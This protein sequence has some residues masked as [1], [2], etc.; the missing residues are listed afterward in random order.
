[1]RYECQ[2]RAGLFLDKTQDR[3]YQQQTDLFPGS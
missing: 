3:R 2:C 1:M